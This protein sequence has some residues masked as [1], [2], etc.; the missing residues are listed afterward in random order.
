MDYR[1]ALPSD[2]YFEYTWNYADGTNIPLT[3]VVKHEWEALPKGLLMLE[4]FFV[5]EK[6]LE[7]RKIIEKTNPVLLGAYSGPIFL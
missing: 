1:I 5:P 4:E 3:V 6:S 2:A 7:L